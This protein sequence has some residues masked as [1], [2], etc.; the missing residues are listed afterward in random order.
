MPIKV[1]VKMTEKT[2]YDF[3]L[4]NHYTKF[5]GIFATILGAFVIILAIYNGMKGNVNTT[6]G[7]IFL[8]VVVL[9]TEPLSLKSSAKRQVSKIKMFQKPLVYTFSDEGLCVTQGK[10]RAM[11]DWNSFIKVVSTK[12]SL[13][14][15]VTRVRAIILPREELAENYG[16]IVEIIRKNVEAKKIKIK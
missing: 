7:L 12:H 3:L 5:S 16:P 11:N 13:I 6:V 4:Y 8:A 2:M 1:K 9:F 10:D 15:Y 14:L